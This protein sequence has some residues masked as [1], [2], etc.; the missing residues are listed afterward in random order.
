MVHEIIFL[1]MK[2][3]RIKLAFVLHFCKERKFFST[4]TSL[5]VHSGKKYLQLSPGLMVTDL[6]F[7]SCFYCPEKA[8]AAHS[9][10]LAWRIPGMEGPG[11]CRLWGH[12]ES[13]T[14]EAT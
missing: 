8:M 14:T 5:N 7:S 9:S 13:D 6:H 12:T 4:K 3:W 11:G 1:V 2:L 10:V